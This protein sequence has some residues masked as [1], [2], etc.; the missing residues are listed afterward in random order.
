MNST[1]DKTSTIFVMLYSEIFQIVE[2]AGM[3]IA[4]IPEDGQVAEINKMTMISPVIQIL[5]H[6]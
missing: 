5:E 1:P 6:Q 2:E 4:W 3:E